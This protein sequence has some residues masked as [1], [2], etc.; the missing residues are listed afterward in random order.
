MLWHTWESIRNRADHKPWTEN[1]WF[2]GCIPS[3][4]FMMWMTHLDRLPTRSRTASWG[5]QS[6]DIC[7]VCN[8]FQVWFLLT[9]RLGYSPFLFHTWTAFM[10]WLSLR[11]SV[12]PPTLRLLVGQ[13]TIYTLWLERNNRLHNSIF[14]TAPAT[15]KRIDRLVR[16]AIL[17]RRNRKKFRNLMLQWLT[18]D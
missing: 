10:E 9:K 8:I 13:A 3:H 6:I 16:N 11:D 18:Y 14:S 4:A 5:T 7:C 12:C 15:F 2:K 1:V 17:A